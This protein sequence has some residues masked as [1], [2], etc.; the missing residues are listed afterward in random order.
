MGKRTTVCAPEFGLLALPATG[1]FASHRVVG[2]G[3][4]LPIYCQKSSA[5]DSKRQ[6]A[7]RDEQL[8]FAQVVKGVGRQWQTLLTTETRSAGSGFG[9][10]GL[11]RQEVDNTKTTQDHLHAL[12]AQ[13][14]VERRQT[15]CP[16]GVCD[17]ESCWLC[18]VM[19]D[20]GGVVS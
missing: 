6:Q 19:A 3:K 14:P 20:N 18:Q 17:C 16:Y 4:R 13:N 11:L 15:T 7:R 8:A 2:A 1:Q 10:P 5:N 12:P 9:R